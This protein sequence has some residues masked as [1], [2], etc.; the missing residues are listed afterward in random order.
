MSANHTDS[1]ASEK[2]I[3]RS[4]PRPR[5]RLSEETPSLAAVIWST[6]SPFPS[7]CWT[8]AYRAGIPV[9]PKFPDSVRSSHPSDKRD[10]ATYVIR[11]PLTSP[12]SGPSP[13]DVS[14]LALRPGQLLS[15]RRDP[16]LDGVLIGSLHEPS[17]SSQQIVLYP[18]AHNIDNRSNGACLIDFNQFA[19]KPSDF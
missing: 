11:R 4:L 15:L 12:A 7:E 8:S 17:G 9:L 16:K 3:S 13:P 2:A 10:V 5:V 6:A 19:A 18:S 14:T 1:S